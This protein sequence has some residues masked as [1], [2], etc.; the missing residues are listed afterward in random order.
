M[1]ERRIYLVFPGQSKARPLPGLPTSEFAAAMQE[2]HH[3]EQSLA[4]GL[5]AV[6]CWRIQLTLVTRSLPTKS[7]QAQA[8]TYAQIMKLETG[9]V[10]NQLI[11]NVSQSGS[12]KIKLETG[13][14]L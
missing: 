10:F 11:L 6:G 3:V 14:L 9:Y 8:N 13:E 2:R 4:A 7:S 5:Q 12:Q 1:A